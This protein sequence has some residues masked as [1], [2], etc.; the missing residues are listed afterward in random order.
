MIKEVVINMVDYKMVE[1]MSLASSPYDSDE[2]EFIKSGFTKVKSELVKPFRVK[3]S[4]VHLECKVNEV[5]ELGH[6]GGA[7]N[8]IICEIL[9]IHIKESILNESNMIDQEKIDLVARMGGNWYSRTDKKSMFEITKPISSKG[10][11]FDQ[12]PN[13]ILSSKF[14]SGNDLG[15]LAGVEFLPNETVVNDFKLIE[16]SELFLE[17]E[18]D[19]K[20]L[21]RSLHE[22]AKEFLAVNDLQAAWKTLLSFNN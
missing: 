22:K 4:P 2:D 14:L 21:E 18:D 9:K 13:E 11:G 1:Q 8:L 7:G 17:L 16:L 10:I 5:K 20:K 15:K 19:P 3:E 6:E 12:I